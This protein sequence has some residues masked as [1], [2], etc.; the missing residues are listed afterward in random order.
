MQRLLSLKASAGS[1]KTFSLAL[2][3]LA[4]LFRGVNPSSILAVTFTNKAANEMKE[5]VIKF[6]DLLKEDEELLE[7]LCGTSGLNEKEILKKR[8]FVLKEFLTS[9]IHITTIDAFIQ[10]VLRK[11][12]YYVGVDVDFDI[13]SDNL[14]NIFELLIESLDNKEF[15][16]LIEFAKIE[17]KKS[18]SIVELFEMLYEKEKELSKWKM[19]NGKWKI[20]Q[21]L[22]EI[23]EIKSEFILATEECT[24]INNFFKK[25]P[26]DMLKVK[27]IPS[28][29]ENGTLAKVRGFK[30]CYEE[31]MDAEFERLIS[32]IKEL[33]TAKERYVLSSLF[34]LYEKYK[35]IKNS[36][37]SKENYLDFKD[38]EHKVYELLVEDEL[39]R[40]FLYFRLDSR[41]EHILIDEFQDTSVTQW[42]IFEPL[43]DEIKAGEGVKDFKS[44][45]YVGDTKQAIYRFRGG[46]SE[47][48][49][50]VYEQLKPF[51]MVQK[52]LPKNYRS[53]KVIVDYVNRLFNLNQEA[54]V[55]GGY[56]E[57]KEGDLFEELE[58]TLKFMFEKGV[59]D[60][61]IAVLVYTNDDILKVADFIKEKFNKDVVTATRAKVKNQPFAKAL[62]DILKYTHDMLEGKKSEIYKLNFLTVI[63]KPYTPEPFYVPVKKPAEMIRDLMFEYD[64]IDESSLKLLEHSLKYKDLFD[65]AAGIDEYDEEL[66]L[67]EFDGITVMTVHKSKGLEFEN[68]IVLEKTGR[69]N[70]RS[71]NLLFDYE[72]IELKD[73]KYNIAGREILDMEFAKV[74]AKEK[75]LEYKDKRNVEYVAFTRAVNSLFI[76]KKEKSSFVTSLKP[77][78]IG[79]F[80][81]EEKEET[82]KSKEKFALKLKHH[83][84]QDVKKEN[85]YKPNDYGAI[86]FGLA[87]HY[88]FEMEEFDAVLNRYGIYTDVKKAYGMYEKTKKLID[89]EGRKYKEIPFV[90]NGE[91]G[92][93]DLLVESEDE[94][95]IIDYK[96]AKP[97]DESS[98]ITQVEHYKTVAKEL[99]NKKVKGYLLYVD[100]EKLREV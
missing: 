5:R 29:L 54:N 67:G 86:Y 30:K 80:E 14:E 35:Q 32:L 24:Q 78:K 4:L 19:E 64:L 79:V 50:Y 81:V 96:S 1:G 12:G 72:G 34:S 51:G 18:K 84:L 37:K 66:P 47:L 11:F 74:K 65:F 93:I 90:Y 87:L 36:V 70:N 68:V 42:K 73:I 75:E 62:I 85:E 95:V 60:K 8:E 21:V 59:R 61:D 25:D 89:F 83:G 20:N 44:F 38:I 71:S 17:N 82:K 41:I 91:E 45:F 99:K 48:F 15:N 69:D 88:A 3:Y 58:N 23:E 31:W 39:N 7:I 43:V 27:T 94:I 63:G 53:K 57:V 46:S 49:D 22:K 77:E 33:L 52:E 97:E 92:I 10:K 26:F 98:Y 13:K 40:D 100:E 76:L 56:V 28:F 55:E 6:L 16:S 2:R 9:D